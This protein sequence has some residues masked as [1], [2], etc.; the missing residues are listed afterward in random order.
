MKKTKKALL[1]AL[2][3]SAVLATGAF[4]L[5]ACNKGD[6]PPAHTHSDS[7][8]TWTVTKK[9]T[10][11]EEG[12]ATRTCT[13]DG[14][15]A[16]AAEKEYALPNLDSTD[17]VKG[18]DSATCVAAGSMQYTYNKNGVNVSFS[19][20]T[21]VNSTAHKYTEGVYVNTDPEGHYQVCQHAATNA[22]HNSQK[23][24]HDTDGTNGVCSVCGYDAHH[25][26]TYDMNTW[27]K[28]ETGHWHPTTCGHDV[29]T[30]DFAAHTYSWAVTTPATEDTEGVETGTCTVEGCGYQTTRSIPKLP[31]ALTDNS[32]DPDAPKAIAAGR[33]SVTLT[34]EYYYPESPQYGM[35][36][37]EFFYK[38]VGGAE[39]KTY[40]LSLEGETG[41]IGTSSGEA[42]TDSVSVVL[43][44]GD[45]Y[46]FSI[47]ADE[48][49]NE[50]GDTVIFKIT[51]S[52]PPAEGTAGRP[53]TVKKDGHFGKADVEDEEK[54]YFMIDCNALGNKTINFTLGQ[55]VVLHQVKE[56][57]L[58][59]GKDEDLYKENDQPVVY[60][61]S[62]S[63]KVN[64]SYNTYF[65]A[66]CRGGDCF[67]DFE[68]VYKDGEKEKPFTGKT[69]AGEANANE[70]TGNEDQWFKLENLAAG[71]YIVTPSNT[72]GS[73]A[74][75]TDVN[76][77]AL[78][79]ARG[80]AI[81]FTLSEATT[82]YIKANTNYYGDFTFNVTEVTE[83][84]MGTA[85]G[86]PIE[87]T[88]KGDIDVKANTTYYKFTATSDGAVRIVFSSDKN[89]SFICYSDANY[90]SYVDSGL[91]ELFFEITSGATYYI[92]AVNESGATGK[93][94][95]DFG[96]TTAH[97]YVITVSDG[98][99]KEFS[100]VTLKLTYFDYTEDEYK[101]IT[102]ATDNGDG[103]YTFANVD[104]TITYNVVISGLPAGYSY[105]RDDL[106]IK[107]NVD[108]T[109]NYT[110]TVIAH[111]KTYT[112]TFTGADAGVDLSGI[113]VTLS[114]RQ[115]GNVFEGTTNAEGVA[116]VIGIDPYANGSLTV[117]VV[118]PENL[119]NTYVYV[120]EK[121][122]L[123]HDR[124]LFVTASKPS[125]EVPLSKMT[126]YNLTLTDTEGAPLS[127]GTVVTINGVSG[128]VGAEG[129]VSIVTAGGVHEI[130]ISD[131]Y[132]TFVKTT[133]AGGELEVTCEKMNAAVEGADSQS[134]AATLLV[135]KTPYTGSKYSNTYAKFVATE[136][137]TYVITA[138][139]SNPNDNMGVDEVYY[140]DSLILSYGTN[141]EPDGTVI[142]DTTA[143][144]FVTSMTVVL[145]EGETIVMGIT[146]DGTVTISKQ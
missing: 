45:E 58:T 144:W 137:G 70:V 83:A 56:D 24:P 21:P 10:K 16:T 79:S 77:K 28:D 25:E 112:V 17:Y 40:T 63:F 92:Q 73:L 32:N 142:L 46:V 44:E 120:P 132:V 143:P 94:N 85:A 48:V 6:T 129:K 80:S 121:D 33:Y 31:H 130:K 122:Q 101:E 54:V 117:S 118:I 8:N 138:V 115:S 109:T 47:S 34:G 97:N 19:V 82:V 71:Q 145:G 55:N 2:A 60:N 50:D 62:G 98:T 141:Y 106:T 72:D 93:F 89:V 29:K 102:G 11:G 13:N 30:K 67:V 116:T 35:R 114:D 57:Y 23:V 41:F 69:G 107:P 108:T 86:L 88:S 3:C 1:A 103:T 22:E 84:D 37:D 146:G 64:G 59:S 87:L 104:P 42:V 96:A 126:T 99:A 5:T 124:E 65:Y 78:A 53:I 105:Y 27:D 131:N 7:W 81:V 68:V 20:D 113:K 135:G 38:I 91:N 74:A 43:G 140:N 66:V 75:Y 123:E 15:N 4:G 14:C 133:A 61:T 136:A 90:E 110:A 76:G 139:T 125:V 95:F 18:A 26:H 49:L 9:P 128:T 12:K 52:D 111:D 39:M 100:G 127:E 134:N 36:V 119:A 51:E